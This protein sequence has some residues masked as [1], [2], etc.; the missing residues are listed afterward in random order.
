MNRFLK[1]KL[2]SFS[3]LIVLF[4][5]ALLNFN[6]SKSESNSELQKDEKQK[7]L[8]LWMQDR[9]MDPET[10]EIP[11][12]IKQKE[13]LFAKTLPKANIS[14]R[15][16]ALEYKIRGPYNLGGRT[17][18]LAYDV[19]NL[20]ILM[21]GGVNGG[22]WKS[23]DNG[24]TWKI[25]TAPNQM[26]NVTAL[27]QDI[28]SGKTDVW[29]FGTGE[30]NGN[31]AGHHG[32]AYLQGNGVYKSTDKGETWSLLASTSA[33]EPRFA[34]DWTTI[35]NI[36]IDESNTAQDE[37]YVATNGAIMRSEDGGVSWVKELGGGASNGYAWVGVTKTGVVYAA[38]GNA[39]GA[40]NVGIWR[41]IDGQNWT[42]ISSGQVPSNLQRI[43]FDIAPSNNNV[44]YFL[45]RT[46]GI[47]SPANPGQTTD[48][49]SSLYKYEYL[50]GNGSGTGGRWIN[51][52]ANI[53]SDNILYYSFSSQ[54]NYNLM[55]KI[56]PN[57][58]NT[59]F[60]GST[61][62]FRSTDAFSTKN[63]TEQIG[64]YNPDFAGNP[65]EYRYPEHHPD[66][67]AVIF[68]N[69]NGNEMVSATDGGLHYTR[70]CMDSKVAWAK[71]NNGYYTS[72]FYTIAIDHLTENSV[73]LGGTQDNGTQ[74]TNSNNEK[75]NW[76]DPIQG[77]GSYCAVKKG[78]NTSG[79]GIYYMSTQNGVTY[80]VKMNDNGTRNSFQRMEY[81]SNGSSYQFIN[82]FTLH[83]NDNNIMY[84]AYLDQLNNKNVVKKQSNLNSI[85]L[86]NGRSPMSSGWSDLP[87]VTINGSITVLK[88]TRKSP[89]HRLYLGTRSGWL[90]RIE[91]ANTTPT[92]VQ[93]PRITQYR[94][95]T[96]V[97]DIAVH[98]VDGNKLLMCFSNYN[99]YSIY[100]S[101]DGGD[102]WQ[103]VAGNLEEKLADGL[104]EA[105]LGQG[106]G[107]SVRSIAFVQAKDGMVCF[108][109]TS[110][111]L[112][113]TYKLDGH[114]TIWIEQATNEIGNTVVEKLDVRDSDKFLAIATHGRGIYSAFVTNST[115]GNSI[116]EDY[117][118]FNN[119][120][121]AFPN[122]AIGT[123]TLSF[124]LDKSDSYDLIIYNELGKVVN[125]K[126]IGV[127]EKGENEIPVS[128]EN[129][130]PGIYYFNLTSSS[131]N[132]SIK[133]IIQ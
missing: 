50:T 4:S 68:R 103:G 13:L 84:M 58:A 114:N 9:L 89:E 32:S 37:L 3:L 69:S 59:V 118:N 51:R 18:A 105:A 132:R 6:A 98:P 38:L 57:N 100:Y 72:Q 107:P 109:G 90:Y 119:S 1:V 83:Y 19:S 61:N 77:D 116:E 78:N 102:T 12:G 121:K 133:V 46:P 5:F 22:I 79:G 71:L 15:G 31:S 120:F 127:V 48:E 73:I 70:N 14:S 16:E 44:L 11:V 43:V 30:G 75:S 88:T 63:N 65:D 86:A 131:N 74:Y 129:F 64:G 27:A 110:T 35:W 111:G 54:S 123:T 62:L 33:N 24:N 52:S 41:S 108:A 47:G 99:V 34:S 49:Y 67:H 128:L 7:E 85:P 81:P 94:S 124:R 56:K 55:I 66:N 122:P 21:A 91:N 80:K 112:Y 8:A 17:R 45:M 42:N 95:G 23:L 40:S 96:Y 93:L 20:Q 130:K 10:G 60:I 101:E 125:C 104:P 39:S 25:K 82:P 92:S 26:H 87:T 115:P 36:A 28:R 2:F 126:N 113:A 106:N 29:Y 117:S 97:S 76:T 53:P